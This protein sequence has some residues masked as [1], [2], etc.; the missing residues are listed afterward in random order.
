M[1]IAFVEQSHSSVPKSFQQTAQGVVI[2]LEVE[3][4]DKYYQRAQ[5]LQLPIEKEICIEPWGQQHFFTIDP[6]GLLVDVYKM[7][8]TDVV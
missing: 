3:E 4:V 7:V 2:T 5:D 6:N 1:Q 8:A